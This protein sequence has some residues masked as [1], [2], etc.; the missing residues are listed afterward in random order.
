MINI[1]MNIDC[2]SLLCAKVRA[3]NDVPYNIT[4]THAHETLQGIYTLDVI[5]LL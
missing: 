1:L 3:V 4:T 2:Y 5:K